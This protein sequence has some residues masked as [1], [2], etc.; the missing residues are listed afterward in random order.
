MTKHDR[1]SLSQHLHPTARPTL[2]FNLILNLEAIQKPVS[3]L[4][5]KP[6]IG[7]AIQDE[8]E[9]IDFEIRVT[10]RWMTCSL[11][12]PLLNMLKE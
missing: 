4:K 11:S 9:A 3:R 5:G 6:G 1:N 12:F 2:G 8:G 7:K 10:P